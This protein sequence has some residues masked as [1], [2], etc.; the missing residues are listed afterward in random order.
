MGNG[1][2]KKPASASNEGPLNLNFAICHKQVQFF[3]QL[4]RSLKMNP[5]YCRAKASLVQ[6]GVLMAILLAGCIRDN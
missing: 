5:D 1:K 6:A 3:S 4:E 2:Q